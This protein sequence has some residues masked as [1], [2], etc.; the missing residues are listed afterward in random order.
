M[1]VVLKI[2][3]TVRSIQ[4]LIHS[5]NTADEGVPAQ[6]NQVFHRKMKVFYEGV[7]V[8]IPVISGNSIRGIIRRLGAESFLKSLKLDPYNINRKLYYMLFSGGALE[9]GEGR[10]KQKAKKAE[11]PAITAEELR[12]YIPLASL[13]GCSFQRQILQG[14]VLVDFLV[15]YVDEIAELYGKPKPG[16]RAREITDWLFY[17]RR[18]DL[19]HSDKEATNQMI[20][21]LEYIVPNIE[22]LHSFTLIGANEVE[23][24]LFFHLMDE[25]NRFGRIGGRIAQGHGQVQFNYP[26]RKEHSAEPYF[27]FIEMNREA[28]LT[29]LKTHWNNGKPGD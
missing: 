26:L 17:T 9:A 10:G 20:Y 6:G 14:K 4:P 19:A 11:T 22:F 23:T 2:E 3:G 28:I 21:Q 15:P 29:L 16:I 1:P 13:L 27:Q 8:F 12:R 7:P 25:L 24:A 18:D 5:A